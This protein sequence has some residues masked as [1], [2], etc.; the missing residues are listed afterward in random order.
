M[1]FISCSEEDFHLNFKVKFI[2]RFALTQLENFANQQETLSI[3]QSEN[4]E[5]EK[6][7]ALL[8]HDLKEA[9]RRFDNE[10]DNRRKAESKVQEL[11][12]H[13]ETEKNIRSQ[14]AMSN[15]QLNDKI[16]SLE[17]QLQEIRDKMKIESENSMKLKKSNA[18]LVMVNIFIVYI[19]VIRHSI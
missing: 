11:Y 8:K 15:Q 7:I 5:M 14:I 2:C 3:L 10:L 18:E 19:C 4:R 6:S 12:S 16:S 13:I 17:K 9:Q 1:H